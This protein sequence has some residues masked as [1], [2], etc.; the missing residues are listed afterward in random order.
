MLDLVVPT[1]THTHT[2]TNTHTPTHKRTYT[3]P[4]MVTVPSS[5][6]T[7]LKFSDTVMVWE[8]ELVTFTTFWTGG[9]GE[10]GGGVGSFD[11]VFWSHI[12]GG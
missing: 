5:R 6:M 12:W 1:H 11:H 8:S 3:N 2:H 9:K 10:G 4:H 7:A